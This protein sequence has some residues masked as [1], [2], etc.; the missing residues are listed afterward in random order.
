M[1][2][3]HLMRTATVLSYHS[4]RAA[5]DHGIFSAD[6]RTVYYLSI[7]DS[8]QTYD[9]KKRAERFVKR[10][11]LGKNAKGISVQPPA[12]YQARFVAQMCE[13]IAAG[14]HRDS[15]SDAL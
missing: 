15:D 1:E 4:Q 14:W 6:H 11:L 12:A 5:E 10:F 7:I 9:L 8:L 2:H 3:S 13:N